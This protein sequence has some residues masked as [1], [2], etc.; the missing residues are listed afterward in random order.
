MKTIHIVALVVVAVLT[1]IIITTFSG[2]ST[3][4]NF[5]EANSN[6]GREFHIIGTLSRNKPI[7][8]NPQIDHNLFSFFMTDPLGHECRVIYKGA[9]PQDFEKSDQVVIIGK[10]MGDAFEASSLLLKCPSKYNDKGLPEVYSD[11]VM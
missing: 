6:Q 9:K 7:E 3:Y 8:Y 2:S 10:M 5:G 11:S 4:S 1:G